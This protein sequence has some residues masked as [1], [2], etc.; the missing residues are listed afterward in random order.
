[1][2]ISDL[3]CVG[4]LSVATVLTARAVYAQ[5][6]GNCTG[7]AKACSL[8]P[9]PVPQELQTCCKAP[10]LGPTPQ[11]YKATGTGNRLYIED[12]LKQCG[13]T[14]RII[15]MGGSRICAEP[16]V[17]ATCG[18]QIASLTCTAAPPAP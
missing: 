3:V 17:A 4:L 14:G 12:H 15:E 13:D 8:T 5:Y 18:G 6:E 1:M 16:A 11:Q 10:Q 7:Y 2:R 9:T